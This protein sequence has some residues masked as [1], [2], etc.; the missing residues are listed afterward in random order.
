MAAVWSVGIEVAGD[1]VMTVQRIGDLADAIAG[2]GGIASGIGRTNYGVTVLVSAADR[3][4]AIA[5]ATQIL[6]TAA[7][8]ANLPEWPVSRV[9]VTSEEEDF[10]P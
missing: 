5:Q 10:E 6:R 7:R 1:E 4:A 9:E 3:D 2:R 8:Q